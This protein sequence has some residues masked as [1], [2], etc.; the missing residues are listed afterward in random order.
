MIPTMSYATE[1]T[2]MDKKPHNWLKEWSE[3]N[4]HSH[5]GF[6]AM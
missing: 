3:T 5:P 1:Y 4:Q 6:P 2:E